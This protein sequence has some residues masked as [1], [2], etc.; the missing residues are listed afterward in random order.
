MCLILI[1]YHA[2]PRYPLVIAAN[3]DEFRRRPT[4][5]AH[6]WADRP[7]LCA[8]RDLVHGGTWLGLTRNGR[9]AA[10]TNYRDP[11]DR[12]PD[13]PSR[14]ELVS[15]FLASPLSIDAF[16][17]QLRRDGP[18][19]L[20]FNLLFGGVD[21]LLWYSNRNGAAEPMTPGIHG[22][23]NEL[24]DTPWPKVTRGKELLAGVLQ[25]EGALDKEELFALLADRTRPPDRLLPQTG[26][27]IEKERLLSTIF[28]DG[29]EYGTR[30]ST[31][32]LVA[33][34]GEVSFQERSFEP[35]LPGVTRSLTLRWERFRGGAAG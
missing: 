8:G 17:A 3:R 35:G 34:H 18:T 29:Q 28:I 30:C 13:A 20:G 11:W 21:R 31:V 9:V 26:I 24:L 22:L 27:G 6:F 4:E 14:G 32:I 23:S 1:A 16:L 25:G 10:L 15:R 2:H 5:G 19:Y 7:E 33:D 12:K